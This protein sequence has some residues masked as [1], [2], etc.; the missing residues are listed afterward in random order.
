MQGGIFTEHFGAEHWLFVFS[1]YCIM[2]W[3]QESAIESL[4]HKHPVNRGFLKGPYIPIY[5]IGGILLLFICMPFR[6]NPFAVF[7]IALSSCT[8]LEY[9]AG[10]MMETFFG[11]QFW[12]YSMMKFT[13]KN[14]ISLLSSLFWG[15]MGLFVTY[16]VA[17]A[18]QFAVMHL[19]MQLI[20][21]VAI[22]I[23]L[24]M[25]VDLFITAKKQIDTE[26]IGRTFRLANIGAH[27]NVISR[28]RGHFHDDGYNNGDDDE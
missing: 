14:R 25:T 28:L 19:P 2:G 16:I 21:A 27:I 15:V 11:K 23:P 13:Y 22:L 4:Y 18:T 7:G 5:G 24:V 1:V 8:L 20:R 12:D 10:W 6:D 26:S 17:D 3:M 9:F